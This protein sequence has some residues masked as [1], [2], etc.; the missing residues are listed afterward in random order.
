MATT[1]ALDSTFKLSSGYEMPRLGF[2]VYQ[3]RQCAEP[4]AAAFKAGYRHI[5]SAQIYRNEDQVG[6]AF[7]ASGLPREE[8]FITTKVAS[9]NQGHAKALASVDESLKKLGLDYVDLFLIHDPLAGKTKRLETY[10]ALL[11]KKEA[12]KIR[13]VGV[14]NYGVHHLEEIAA[15]GLPTPTVNQIELHPWC[16]QRPIVEYCAKNNIV[17]EA[18]T[19][20]TQGVKFNDPTLKEIA[21]AHGKEPAQVLIRWS[22]QKGYSPLPKSSTPSRV[23]SNADVYSFALSDTEMDKLDALDK[24]EKGAVTWNPVNAGSWWDF[25]PSVAGRLIAKKV[26]LA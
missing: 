10:K 26:G 18:Y 19:P 3:I 9:R 7:R 23:T 21:K 6:E 4:I 1:L 16:Q 24:A 11:E 25:I 12:G 14:S 2:G 22:L 15:A 8:V 13:S 17:V 5:D 20:L